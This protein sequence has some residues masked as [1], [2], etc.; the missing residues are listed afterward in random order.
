[1]FNSDFTSPDHTL[2]NLFDSVIIRIPVF[3]WEYKYAVE[4]LLEIEAIHRK[5]NKGM[6]Q[7]LKAL[8]DEWFLGNAVQ[9]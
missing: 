8:I 7:R 6:S 9:E 5:S 2:N 1:M 3:I 4:H